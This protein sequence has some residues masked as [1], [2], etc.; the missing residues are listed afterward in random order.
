MCQDEFCNTTVEGSIR[1]GGTIGTT[2]TTFA[3]PQDEYDFLTSGNIFVNTTETYE[4][5][6]YFLG[7]LTLGNVFASVPVTL[8][9]C[10]D[11][12]LGVLSDRAI[13]LELEFG[14]PTVNLEIASFFINTIPACSADYIFKLTNETMEPEIVPDEWSGVV[15][16]NETMLSMSH[17]EPGV[18]SFYLMSITEMLAPAYKQFILTVVPEPEPE[19][20]IAE[21]VEIV[22]EEVA[23]LEPYLVLSNFEPQWSEP[24]PTEI[25]VDVVIDSNFEYVDKSDF[26]YT[27]PI[28]TDEEED[29]ISITFDGVNLLEFAN[30]RTNDDNS[31][32]ITVKRTYITESGRY[33]IKV[34]LRD[35]RNPNI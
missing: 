15:Q 8:Q 1:S 17:G 27:S 3:F 32:T 24:L 35:D 9:V 14:D 7:A 12:Q 26:T 13:E 25:S 34:F 2:V 5:I 4:P 18:Y 16:V 22:E 28:A 33:P 6:Q 31:Y 29:E 19:P 21:L 30:D 20:E 10:G 23:D 11:E